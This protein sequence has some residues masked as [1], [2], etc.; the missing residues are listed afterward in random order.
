MRVMWILSLSFKNT[1]F[2]TNL[3]PFPS[4]ASFHSLRPISFCTLR[5][6]NRTST[7]FFLLVTIERRSNLTRH[8]SSLC[9]RFFLSSLSQELSHGLTSR[10]HSGTPHWQTWTASIT[11]TLAV[12]GHWYNKGHCN[13]RTVNT[14]D[15]FCYCDYKVDMTYRGGWCA[16]GQ[17]GRFH[18]AAQK[19]HMI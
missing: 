9:T 5:G 18:R 13:T 16:R 4:L 2:N 1:T 14:A 8:L 6:N 15:L 17:V 11:T 3:M 19:R 10:K 7:D 12:W